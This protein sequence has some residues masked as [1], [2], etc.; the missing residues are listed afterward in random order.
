[1]RRLVVSAVVFVSGCGGSA[2]QSASPSVQVTQLPAP[3]LV[4]LTDDG[5]SSNPA[6]IVPPG[7]VTITVQNGTS[8]GPANFELVRLA[9]TFEEADQFL[10]DVRSGLESPPGELFFIAEEADRSLVD[11]GA[12]GELVAELRAGTYAVVCVPLD[13]NEDIITAFVVGPYSVEN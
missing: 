6:G 4:A 13:E 8:T 1:M 5:C 3:Q 10:A 12:A 2:V 7:V 11:I 9:G